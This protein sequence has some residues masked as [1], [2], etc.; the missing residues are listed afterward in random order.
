MARKD[1]GPAFPYHGPRNINAMKDSP[2]TVVECFAPGMSLRAWLAGQ[3]LSEQSQHA[4]SFI[5]ND[6]ARLFAQ[7]AVLVADA[8]IAELEK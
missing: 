2:P 6:D 8:L 4:G 1:G 3:W 5:G 7:E